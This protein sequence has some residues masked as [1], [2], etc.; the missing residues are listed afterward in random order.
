VF[1]NESPRPE[2]DN[3]V[4][5]LPLPPQ[6][7]QESLEDD[8]DYVPFAPGVIEDNSDSRPPGGSTG[9]LPLVV[10]LILL[11]AGAGTA[12][13]FVFKHYRRKAIYRY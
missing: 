11:I 12:A 7:P 5:T 2:P 10:I 3:T 9:I 4:N 13:P 6:E 1:F 8:L